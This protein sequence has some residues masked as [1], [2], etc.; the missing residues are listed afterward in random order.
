MACFLWDSLLVTDCD[1]ALR[2]GISKPEKELP[3]CSTETTTSF[4]YFQTSILEPT[5][6]DTSNAFRNI[7]KD[8]YH[9]ISCTEYALSL[10]ALLASW[11][12]L[13]T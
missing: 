2:P 12:E 13:T 8:I 9:T 5:G 1:D 3:S 7:I 4:H 11:R 6:F 10:E